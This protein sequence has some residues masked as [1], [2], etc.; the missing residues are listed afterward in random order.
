MKN[1]NQSESNIKEINVLFP[2][3]CPNCDE[4]IPLKSGVYDGFGFYYCSEHCLNQHRADDCHFECN[5]CVDN[6]TD[7]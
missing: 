3:P 6:N 2:E 4:D 5:Y 7:L 1:T